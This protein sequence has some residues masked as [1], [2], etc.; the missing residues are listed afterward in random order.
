MHDNRFAA[1]E[2]CDCTVAW[3]ADR[4]ADQ[5]GIKEGHWELTRHPCLGIQAIPTLMP[6]LV[7]YSW[8]PAT[9][10]WTCTCGWLTVF[11]MHLR[12]QRMSP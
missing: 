7:V 4:T 6:L 8:K 11:P 2:A 1:S 9:V 10:S 12:G 5:G 3:H